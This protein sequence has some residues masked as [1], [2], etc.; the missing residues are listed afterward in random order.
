MGSVA[1]WDVEA[2]HLTIL[3]GFVPCGNT[4]FQ[5]R[6]IEVVALVIAESFIKKENPFY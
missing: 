6:G 1:Q 4:S 3:L 2:A 5:C